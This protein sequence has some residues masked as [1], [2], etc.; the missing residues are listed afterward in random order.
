MTEGIIGILETYDINVDDNN[1][2][3]ASI[4]YFSLQFI[5]GMLPGE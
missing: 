4:I 5:N 2:M 1:R 3:K